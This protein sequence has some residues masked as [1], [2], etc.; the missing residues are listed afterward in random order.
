MDENIVPIDNPNDGDIIHHGYN[1][2]IMGN[3]N[4]IGHNNVIGGNMPWIIADNFNPLPGEWGFEPPENNNNIMFLNNHGLGVPP[5]GF[6]TIPFNNGKYNIICRNMRFIEYPHLIFTR[7]DT[8]LFYII[9]TNNIT[10]D[11]FRLLNMFYKNMYM[12]KFGLKISKEYTN[13]FDLS[14][15]FNEDISIHVEKL[16]SHSYEFIKNIKY[17]HK[18]KIDYFT[19]IQFVMDIVKNI[20]I[21]HLVISFDKMIVGESDDVMYSNFPSKY[22]ESLSDIRLMETCKSSN[23]KIAKKILEIYDSNIKDLEILFDIFEQATDMQKLKLIGDINMFSEYL[24]KLIKNTKTLKYYSGTTT[25][26]IENGLELNESIKKYVCYKA[27]QDL[28]TNNA[29]IPFHVQHVPYEIHQLKNFKISKNNKIHFYLGKLEDLSNDDFYNFIKV[30]NFDRLKLSYNC[31]I[32]NN[33]NYKLTI[34]NHIKKVLQIL[35]YKNIKELKLNYLRVL[36]ISYNFNGS[37]IQKDRINIDVGSF[38]G[39]Y[40]I[41]KY[42]ITSDVYF[43]HRSLKKFIDIQSNVLYKKFFIEDYKYRRGFK[44]LSIMLLFIKN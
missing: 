10:E 13:N 40:H 29:K 3:N 15:Y 18:L 12:H 11:D 43:Y 9:I 31:H 16:D 1:N 21:T 17:I 36:G 39:G 26:R 22:K 35:F 5:N 23:N 4:V 34:E 28:S 30:N 25:D 41:D 27:D 14:L 24:M 20:S 32:I 7:D 37:Y 42:V 8:N 6:M 2:I 19:D 44:P 38:F 33:N